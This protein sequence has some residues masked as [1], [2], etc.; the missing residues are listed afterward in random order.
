MK[1]NDSTYQALIEEL[2]SKHPSV[3]SAGFGA[4]AYKPGLEGMAAFDNS[5][6]SPWRKFRT[7]HIAG[8][9]G[10]GSVS[11]MLAAALSAAGF[12]VGLYTSPH[13][14]DFRE[15]IKLI[16]GEMKMI[17][18]EDVWEFL[19]EKDTDGLS[20]FEITTGMAFWWFAEQEVDVA[21]IEVGLGGRLD[22]T[23]IITPELSVITSIGLD[24]CAMLGNTRA[25]IAAEKAGI[26]KP[27]V[28]AL[29]ATTDDETAPVFERIASEVHCPLFF[30]DSLRDQT[31]PE[32]SHPSETVITRDFVNGRGPRPKAWEGWSEAKVYGGVRASGL[33]L[34]G[35]CQTINLRTVLCA[36]DLLGVEPDMEAI[37]HTAAI[38]GFHGRWERLMDNPEVICDI[39]HNPAAL[40]INFKRLSELERPLIIVYGIMADKDLDGIAPLMP[41]AARY[42]LAA[43]ATERSLKVGALH[44]RLRSLRPDLLTETA[45]CVADAV[46]RALDMAVQSPGSLVYIGGST[47]VVS[48]AITSLHIDI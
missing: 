39:G 9:N 30:A 7:I 25:E 37:R 42:I 16:D 34:E 6:G 5:L 19:T 29:V 31:D 3:Q 33:D 1:Y 36:L 4:G 45:P 40:A 28:P 46:R 15:R 27:G 8:T 11:S 21:V 47:F 26:F 14:V 48:E 10:K 43:P 17:P 13:L 44:D 24:H 12:K 18:R 41:S 32:G 35:P 23:N 2:F 20:F 38:T 22:S